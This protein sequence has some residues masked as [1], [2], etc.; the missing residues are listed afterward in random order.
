MKFYMRLIDRSLWT[1]AEEPL[2]YPA[3]GFNFVGVY[4][5]RHWLFWTRWATNDKRWVFYR[6]E[7][8]KVVSELTAGRIEDERVRTEN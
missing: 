8:F 7:L 4:K 2:E 5:K 1:N 3:E 6:P